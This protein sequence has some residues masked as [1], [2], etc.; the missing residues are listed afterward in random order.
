MIIGTLGQNPARETGRTCGKAKGGGGKG[1][2]QKESQQIGSV[3]A[4]ETY[5]SPCDLTSSE[6]SKGLLGRPLREGNASH[7]LYT[8]ES[9]V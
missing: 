5:M 3:T 2:Y 9:E 7:Q 8:A 1:F 6:S 4:T